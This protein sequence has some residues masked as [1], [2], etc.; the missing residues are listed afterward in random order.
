[1]TGLVMLKRRRACEVAC[2]YTGAGLHKLR[3][4]QQHD[5]LVVLDFDSACMK[6][7]SQPSLITRQVLLGTI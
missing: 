1:M 6:T 4:A 3:L 2:E 5:A 7:A